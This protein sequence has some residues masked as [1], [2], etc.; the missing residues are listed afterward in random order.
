[1]QARKRG[2]LSIENTDHWTPES[3]LVPCQRGGQNG[4]IISLPHSCD[5]EVRDSQ[6][7]YRFYTRDIRFICMHTYDV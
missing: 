1:M 4:S 3:P 5:L 7:S 2:A 6:R